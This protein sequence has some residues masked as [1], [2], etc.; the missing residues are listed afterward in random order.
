VLRWRSRPKIRFEESAAAP[1]QKPPST[2]RTPAAS[3]GRRRLARAAAQHVDA[4]RETPPPP[5]TV[6]QEE[7]NACAASGAGQVAAANAAAAKAQARPPSGPHALEI[8][9]AA[10]GS[11]T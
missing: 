2:C 8:S 11:I 3:V 4:R 9:G 1:C 6:C 10:H 7:F 5:S